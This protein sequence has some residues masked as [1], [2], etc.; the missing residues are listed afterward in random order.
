VIA[1]QNGFEAFEE[2]GQWVFPE[3]CLTGLG[4]GA[5]PMPDGDRRRPAATEVLLPRQVILNR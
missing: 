1:K 3:E 2:A 4:P 5:S